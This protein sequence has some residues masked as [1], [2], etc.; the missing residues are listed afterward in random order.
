M[1]EAEEAEEEEVEEEAEEE[2]VIAKKE[3]RGRDRTVRSK[4]SKQLGGGR[5]WHGEGGLDDNDN[6]YSGGSSE[7]IDLLDGETT[8]KIGWDVPSDMSTELMGERPKAP[9]S[10]VSSDAP[11]LPKKNDR[12]SKKVERRETRVEEMT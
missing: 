8:T 12:Y 1:V 6:V 4:S 10:P 7:D 5:G 9:T 3:G 11:L 2:R